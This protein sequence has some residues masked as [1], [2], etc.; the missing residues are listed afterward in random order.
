MKLKRAPDFCPWCLES[1]FYGVVDDTGEA[2]LLDVPKRPGK[3]LRAVRELDTGI[4]LV[5]DSAGG[6]TWFDRHACAQISTPQLTNAV[7]ARLVGPVI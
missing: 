7:V 1:C 5:T 4:F 3:D 2:V 6:G